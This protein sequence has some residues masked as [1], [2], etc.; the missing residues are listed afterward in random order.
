MFDRLIASVPKIIADY[1]ASVLGSVLFLFGVWFF[2]FLIDRT[3]RRVLREST[4]LDTSYIAVIAR[5]VRI[6]IVTLAAIA[7]NGAT[8]PAA[9][10]DLH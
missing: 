2:A 3:I 6:I 5:T 4:E 8:S 7:V 1:G 10:R 9:S